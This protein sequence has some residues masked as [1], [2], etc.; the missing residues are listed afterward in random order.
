MTFFRTSS[1]DVWLD[2]VLSLKLFTIHSGV[3][4][5]S[6]GVGLNFVLSLKAQVHN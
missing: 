4:L 1:E 2:F 3:S 5:N 6:V